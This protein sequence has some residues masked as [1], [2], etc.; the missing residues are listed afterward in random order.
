MSKQTRGIRNCNP[1]NIR[2]GCNWKGL[3]KTQTDKEFCQFTTMS[4]GLRALCVTLRT[5]ITKRKCI[6][7]SKIIN[8]WAP[9]SD[10]NN[11]RE[12]IKTV[13][14]DVG[15]RLRPELNSVYELEEVGLNYEFSSSDLF[16][17]DK[18]VVSKPFFAL[19]KTICWVES[20]YMLDEDTLW[21]AMLLM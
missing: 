18:G 6:S 12:Y 10:H 19:V 21:F 20:Q 17:D 5:Y 4:W 16:T 7:V 11:T 1:G 15:K 8:R 9:P 14:I 2:K 3:R 13:A